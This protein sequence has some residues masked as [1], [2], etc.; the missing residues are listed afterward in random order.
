M[1]LMD[2][3]I[4]LGIRMLPSFSD[5][6]ALLPPQQEGFVEPYPSAWAVYDC[7]GHVQHKDTTLKGTVFTLWACT[8]L[9]E[10]FEQAWP[11]SIS[12]QSLGTAG[13]SP[14]YK[15]LFQHTWTHTYSARCCEYA[16]IHSFTP[17]H[18]YQAPRGLI[19]DPVAS[20]GGEQGRQ[21]GGSPLLLVG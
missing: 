11:C 6:I 8:N 20:G 4:L 1:G 10:S 19:P 3:G 14:S 16:R 7:A 12:R 13:E 15:N 5:Q 2:A 9:K 18:V 21:T 17:I